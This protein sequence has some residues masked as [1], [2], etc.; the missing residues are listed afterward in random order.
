MS[1]EKERNLSV[2][3]SAEKNLWPA[4]KDAVEVGAT[5]LAH[6]AK[7]TALNV[8]HKAQEYGVQAMEQTTA[9]VRKYPL[10]SLFAFLGLGFIAGIMISRR[11]A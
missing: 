5:D 8:G 10:Q 9:T 6:K 3:S 11:R 7:E 1:A 2:T 4:A